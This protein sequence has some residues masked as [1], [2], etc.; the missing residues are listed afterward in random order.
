MPL[1]AGTS[2][3]TVSKNISEIHK[4][5]R[6]EKIKE[7]HGKEVADK[8]AV[9][10]AMQKKRESMSERRVSGGTIIRRFNR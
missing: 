5:P 10:A 8:S 7:K 1:K 4:G 9:A 2:P 3:A 6:Y